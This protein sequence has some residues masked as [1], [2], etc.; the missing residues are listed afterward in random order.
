[1]IYVKKYNTDNG[2]MLAMCD[3]DL[4]DKVL[5]DGDIEINIKDYSD[6]YKGELIDSKSAKGI[7]NAE[8]IQSAN[9]IGNEAV[10]AAIE[11]SVI[12]KAHVKRIKNIPYA[13]AY[14]TKY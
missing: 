7:I 9:V 3:A 2:V 12:E 13:Q 1:M 4:I 8:G 10:A 14:S 11:N 5:K 6:F